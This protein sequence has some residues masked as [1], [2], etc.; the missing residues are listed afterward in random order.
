MQFEQ[1]S[2]ADNCV[3]AAGSAVGC[4]SSIKSVVCKNIAI[5]LFWVLYAAVPSASMKVLVIGRV[6]SAATCRLR[7]STTARAHQ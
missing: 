5:S 7:L 2:T 1:Y 6:T 3:I 4:T